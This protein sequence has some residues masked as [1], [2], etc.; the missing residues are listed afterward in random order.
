MTA[1][2]ALTT[3][4]RTPELRLLDLDPG[5]RRYPSELFGFTDC[6]PGQA[7]YQTYWTTGSW[8]E[9][10]I[11]YDAILGGEFEAK[12][13]RPGTADTTAELT[14]DGCLAARRQYWVR[15]AGRDRERDR[16]Q[17]P[18]CTSGPV[19]RHQMAGQP[20]GATPRHHSRAHWAVSSHA[21]SRTSS[22]LECAQA[23]PHLP[24]RNSFAARPGQPAAIERCV[25]VSCSACMPRAFT[26]VDVSVLP[27]AAAL[28]R[29]ESASSSS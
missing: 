20:D 14:G 18:R 7:A 19:W 6:A 26:S 4:R 5:H 29:I 12:R 2:R 11:P 1:D 24:R 27:I 10:L 21:Y 23:K 22:S 28:A 25:V 16:A 9:V 3:S 13:R 8:V 17:R 15:V